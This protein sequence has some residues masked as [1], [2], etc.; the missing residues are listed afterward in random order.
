MK[1]L[2]ALISTLTV[3]GISTATVAAAPHH[4]AQYWICNT[5]SLKA[6][7]AYPTGSYWVNQINTYPDYYAQP[8]V[9][10][11]WTAKYGC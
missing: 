5:P 2:L 11:Y 9:N 7:W 10:A 8:S 3:L 6:V 1:K 4:T